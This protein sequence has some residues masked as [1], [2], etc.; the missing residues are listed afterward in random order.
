MKKTVIVFS[1]LLAVFLMV[2]CENKGSGPES[3]TSE[4]MAAPHG[5]VEKEFVS[6]AGKVLE[7][8]DGTEFT[9]VKIG[10]AAGEKW[11]AVPLTDVA[12][13]EEIKIS[14][15]EVLIN[16]PSKTLGRTFPELI[17]AMGIE[18]KSPKTAKGN[19]LVDP[20]G[21]PPEQKIQSKTSDSFAAAMQ[22]ERGQMAAQQ[23]DFDPALLGSN[24]AIVPFVELKIDKATGK[25]GYT[26]GELFEKGEALNGKKIKVRGQVVKVSMNIMKKNWLHIQDGTGDTLKNTHD[27][28]VTTSAVPQKGS[29]VVVEGELHAKRDFGAGYSYPVIVEDAM[30]SEE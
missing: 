24:K 4:K 12:V 22:A 18:G 30:I 19:D 3:A 9:Y 23:P 29:I 1:G 13:G 21:N 8:A 25:N 28:V 6:V 11:V 17:V 16:F 15:G 2:S 20:H 5:T 10:T 7:V 14:E 26:V 27:L